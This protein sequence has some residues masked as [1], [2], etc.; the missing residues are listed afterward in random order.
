MPIERTCVR[1]FSHAVSRASSYACVVVPASCISI[2]MSRAIERPSDRPTRLA[3]AGSH[4]KLQ[5]H[6]A[7]WEASSQRVRAPTKRR[8]CFVVVLQVKLE[9]V[10]S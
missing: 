1:A 5:R 2:R 9:N 10:R 8:S 7:P 3:P 6:R 4:V